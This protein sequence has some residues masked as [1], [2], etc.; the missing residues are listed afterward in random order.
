M[1]RR[2]SPFHNILSH[3][4]SY[5]LKNNEI[6][7]KEKDRIQE[8]TKIIDFVNSGIVEIPLVDGTKAATLNLKSTTTYCSL[9]PSELHFEADFLENSSPYYWIYGP[10]LI[11]QEGPRCK[12]VSTLDTIPRDI[13]KEYDSTIERGS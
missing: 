5:A 12:G 4:G 10:R 11:A 6:H 2:S 1:S 9:L 3:Y 8:N 7:G 13:P